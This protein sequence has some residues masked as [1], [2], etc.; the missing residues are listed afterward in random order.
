MKNNIN[1]IIHNTDCRSGLK[2]IPSNSVEFIVTDPPYFIDGMGDDWNDKNLKNKALKSGVV[3]GLPVGMKFDR[4]QG[5]KLQEFL[6][7]IC[8]EFF[9]ILKPGGFCII[10]S[11][12]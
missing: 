6:E 2:D 9:R 8:D 7:P 4:E 10:F 1:Y 5:R 12:L 11:Q 3:G